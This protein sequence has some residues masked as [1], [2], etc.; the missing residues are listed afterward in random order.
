MAY[1][2]F[3]ITKYLIGIGVLALMC[4][5]CHP[6]NKNEVPDSLSPIFVNIIEDFVKMKDYVSTK[7]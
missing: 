3:V 2:I 4:F 6:K 7:F 1:N 5:Y